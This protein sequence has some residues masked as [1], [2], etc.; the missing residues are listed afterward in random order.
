M[1]SA[2]SG[3]LAQNLEGPCSADV[4]H[5]PGQQHRRP[6]L[7]AYVDDFGGFGGGQTAGGGPHAVRDGTREAE[8][9]RGE[10]VEVDR[11]TVPG[12]GTV[13]AA[14]IGGQVPGVDG[15]GGSCRGVRL[16]VVRTGHRLGPGRHGV[17]GQIP[18]PG[19]P[20]QLTRQPG[21][22]HHDG[23]GTAPVGPQLIG[24]YG[25]FWLIARVQGPPLGNLDAG[26][27]EP[28][29]RQRESAGRHQPHGQRK[30]EYMRIGEGE[31]SA[32][33]EATDPGVRGETTGIDARPAPN[34]P[35]GG[36]RRLGRDHTLERRSHGT[37]HH[38]E[39]QAGGV[40]GAVTHD[41]GSVICK[42]FTRK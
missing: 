9:P 3:P 5:G 36:Q 6:E 4:R 42:V 32:R 18:A 8:E 27:D 31:R 11:V 38:G 35:G 25:E 39:Q 16:G 13:A 34:Q 15:G 33:I 1:R 22:G 2:P 10:G 23:F 40:R 26:M 19:L 37:A 21:L 17:P 28:E 12:G 20:D 24:V 14:E 41:P 30:A 7:D 29:N